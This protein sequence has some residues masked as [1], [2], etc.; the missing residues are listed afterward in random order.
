M[1][2]N[3]EGCR[4]F[5]LRAENYVTVYP[6]NI[7]K[8]WTERISTNQRVEWGGGWSNDL[9]ATIQSLVATVSLR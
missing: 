7:Y 3:F 2:N 9:V 8:H 5:N 4:T 1:L 6:T